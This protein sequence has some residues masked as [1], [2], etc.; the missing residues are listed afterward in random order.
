MIDVTVS[1]QTKLEKSPFYYAVLH[2]VDPIKKDQYKWKSTKVRYIDES[3]KRLHNQAEQEASNK[4]EEIRQ[5]FE[6]ELNTTTIQKRQDVLFSNYSLQWLDSISKTKKKSTIGGYESNIKSIICPYFEK[7]RIKLTELTT[8]DLQDFYDYQYKLGKDP[9][10][11]LH[12]YR[13]IN[14]TLEKARKTKLIL[15]NPNT[16]CQIVKPDPYIPSVYSK[17]ELKTFLDK[18]KDTDIAV[19]IMLIGVYGLRR[20]EAIGVKWERVNFEDSQLTIAHTVVQTTINKKRIVDKKDIP[21]NNSSYRTFPLKDFLK[22]FLKETYE[23][24]E[25]N[26]KIF[27]NSYLNKENYV[28]VK[29]DGSL[30]LPDTLSKKFKKFLKDNNLREI[31]LHDLRHSV[32]TILLNNGAHLRE[33]QDNMGH[34]NVS[35]TEI[36]THLDSSSKEHTA[37]IMNDILKVG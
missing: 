24:Q 26:K 7:K 12:Y 4:A 13:N 19:P 3:K 6:K 33:V 37:N 35:T 29:M 11:V 5:N 18:I 14:Q 8:L 20:S 31:R 9:R 10:T 27:G 32:A 16:D 28:C 15:V 22:E 1:L 17:K 2:W 36:Y 25:E 21:K 34:S 30:I 23:R